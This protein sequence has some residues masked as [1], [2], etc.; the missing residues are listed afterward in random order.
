MTHNKALSNKQK[1]R[2]KKKIE[3]QD[4]VA[5]LLK[6]SFKALL[7]S[8][9]SAFLL[10]LISSA[11]TLNIQDPGRAVRPFG[12]AVLII[13][14]LICGFSTQKLSSSSPI[15][16]GLTSAFVLSTVIL[17]SSLMFRKET[18]GFSVGVRSLM[19]LFILIASTFGAILGN[20]R[21]VKKRRP[22]RK[23]R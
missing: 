18:E 1:S 22:T 4:P 8:L 14:A 6:G 3:S 5:S 7:I 10:M 23:Y 9:L 21:L 15:W 2:Q 12:I 17:V 13:T 20:A 11:I 16:S 19:L